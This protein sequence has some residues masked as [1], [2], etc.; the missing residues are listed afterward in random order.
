MKF[1][2]LGAKLNEYGE[3]PNGKIFQYEYY[4]LTLIQ[5][6]VSTLNSKKNVFEFKVTVH[7]GLW[8]KCTQSP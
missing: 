1:E 7:Y 8:A 2:V 5:D 4:C 3:C 6:F